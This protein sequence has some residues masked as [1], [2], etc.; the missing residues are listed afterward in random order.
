M[1]L[2]VAQGPALHHSRFAAEDRKL[3]D[4]A[5]ERAIGKGD[6]L[7]GGVVMI[8]TQTLEQSL[9]IDAD[10]LISDICPVDVL[11]Q[12]IG[13]LHRH[14]RTDRPSGFRAPQCVVLVPEAGLESGLDGSLLAHG[15]GVSNRGGIYVNLLGLEATRGLI[16]DHVTWTIPAMN[17]MLVERATHPEMLRELS[18]TLG[19]RWLSHEAKVFGL[20][21]AEAGIART[22]ALSR[23]EPFD[24]DLAFPDLDEKVRTRLGEDGPRIVLADPVPGPFGTPVQTFNLPAHLFRGAQPGKEEIKAARAKP[25][26][27]GGLILK[28]GGRNL[29][30]DRTGIRSGHA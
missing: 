12:R 29:T 30:Y 3:L 23:E 4:D 1:V 20:R 25:V 17:R 10:L 22:H 13:R 19:G 9:D 21:A 27:A 24:E 2:A 28:V 5:V 15:L 16:A 11:L 14:A 8:G 18:E 6:R 26:P 7:P